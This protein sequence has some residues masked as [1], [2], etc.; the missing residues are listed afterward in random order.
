MKM[1]DRLLFQLKQRGISVE[2]VGDD[3]LKMVGNVTEATPEIV[4][5]VKAFKPELLERLRP[6]IAEIPQTEVIPP[7]DNDGLVHCAECVSFVKPANGH[8]DIAL[9]CDR[10]RCPYK[11]KR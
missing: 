2:Y 1:L 9:L 7:D 6:R 3:S 8:K 4:S 10:V 5:A 11:E